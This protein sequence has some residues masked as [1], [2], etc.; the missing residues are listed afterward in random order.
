MQK[1]HIGYS[2]DRFPRDSMPGIRN[3]YLV[4]E[5]HGA[6]LSR[7]NYRGSSHL[8][9][10]HLLFCLHLFNPYDRPFL[11]SCQDLF[12]NIKNFDLHNSKM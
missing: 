10:Y 4:I 3:F 9:V 7:V 6:L 8:I 11:L 12:R 2:T 5:M 1:Q